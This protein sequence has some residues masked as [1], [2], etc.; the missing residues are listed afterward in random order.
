MWGFWEGANWIPSSS[1]YKRDWTPTP[2][3]S[4]YHD[5]IYKEWWTT[6]SGVTGKDGMFSTK[7]FYGKYK[8]TVNGV[9]KVIDL[10]KSKGKA[11]ID[12]RN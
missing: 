2:S 6:E 12:F 1:M 11:T 4:A 10:A 9:T 3:A 7:A 8:V 5:L